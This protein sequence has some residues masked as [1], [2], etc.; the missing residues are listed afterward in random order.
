MSIARRRG[1]PRDPDKEAA[2]VAAASRLFLERGLAAASMDE[3]AAAAGVAKVT[4]YK[5]FPDKEALFREVLH[6]KCKAMVAPLAFDPE[7]RSPETMLVEM[8]LSFLALALDEEAMALHRVIMAEGPRAPRIAELF[9]EAAVERVKEDLARYFRAENA[10]GRLQIADPE[11]LAWRFLGAVKGEAH[12]R[13]M[14]GLAPLAPEVIAE[15]VAACAR[16]LVR[17]HGADRAA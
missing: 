13:A 2:I 1:R 4:I 6:R 8:G 10:A 7:G 16:D 9:F 15:H 11:R 17:A 3:I 14:M 5:R 12:M